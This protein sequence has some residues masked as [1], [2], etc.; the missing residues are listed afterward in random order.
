MKI[1]IIRKILMPVIAT[2]QYAFLQPLI[3]LKDLL[4]A[5]VAV[6][7]TIYLIKNI[8]DFFG[9]LNAKDN[10]GMWDAGQ[11]VLGSLAIASIGWILT[12]LGIE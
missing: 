6:V 10:S 4:I 9:A 2:G 8:V 11:R 3:L 7:G 1:L 12:F 5:S